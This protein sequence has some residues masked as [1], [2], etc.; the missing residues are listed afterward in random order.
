[1]VKDSK[2]KTR[3]IAAG[4]KEISL[5]RSRAAFTLVSSIQDEVH[6]FAITYHH[7]SHGKSVIRS[8]LT[9]IEGIGPARARELL[10]HFKTISA[11]YE[12][13]VEELCTVKGMNRKAAENIKAQ[14]NKKDAEE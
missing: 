1:M 14:K 3:A 6:R 4:G 13:S 5:N 10:K 12:A 8:S 9:E 11:V 7:A 2:H